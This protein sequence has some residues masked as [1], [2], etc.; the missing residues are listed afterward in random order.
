[1]LVDNTAPSGSVTA[2]P[3]HVAGRPSING[4]AK[5]SGSGIASWQLQIAPEGSSEWANACTVQRTPISG[6]DYGCT[7]NTTAHS[8][9]A[10]ELRAVITDNA[11]NI[12]TASAVAMDIDNAALSGSIA[13]PEPF[14][15][16]TIKLS[17]TGSSTG[18]SVAS[19]AVQIASLGSGAWSS[20]CATQTMPVSGSEYRCEMNSSGFTDGTYELR[21]VVTD[22]EGDTY[23]TAP[24]ETVIDN[25]PP[26]GALYQPPEKVVGEL[27]V[28]GYA[29]DNG[30]GVDTWTLERAPVGSESF[31]EACLPQTVPISGLIYGCT[32]STGSLTPGAYKLR[33]VILDGAGNTYTTS[34]VSTMVESS[35]LSLVSSPSISGEAVSEEALSVSTGSWSGTGTIGYSYQWRKCNSS[36]TECANIE[37]ATSNSYVL[38]SS[39]V[40]STL[41]VVVIASNG[42]EESSVTSSASSV[43]QANGLANITV[44]GISGSPNVGATV[45]AEPGRW[46]GVSP[47]SYGYQWQLC[48]GSGG[49]CS[50]I[51]GATVSA[52][53]LIEGDL[54]KTLRVVVT[55]TN[56]EGSKTATST[57]TAK[58]SSGSSS[59]IRYLY[60][61]VGRLHIV[62][63][64][65]GGAAVYSWDADGNLTGIKRYS[66]STLAVLAVTPAHA[67]PGTQVDITGTDFNTNPS[68]DE[69]HFNGISATVSK[70][71]VT[72]LIV[73]VPEGAT[74]GPI[75][76][77]IS[78]ESAESPTSFKPFVSIHR[79][80]PLPSTS[81]ASAPAITPTQ[82]PTVIHAMAKPAIGHSVRHATRLDAHRCARAKHDRA[83]KSRPQGGCAPTHKTSTSARRG[84]GR[85]NSTHHRHKPTRAKKAK[86]SKA[87]KFSAVTPTAWPAAQVPPASSPQSLTVPPAMSDYRSPYPTTWH[88]TASNR[89]DDNWVTGR[90][91]SPWA[92]LPALHTPRSTTGLSGQ[93]LAIS[94]EPL[95]NVT[96][97]IQGTSKQTRTDNTGRFLLG[98]LEP[99][100]Q[101]LIIEGE[102]AN[103]KGQHYGRFT[104]G[105]DL[106]KDKIMPLES[107]IWMTPLEAAGNR[108]IE[109]PLKHETTL[110]NPN[111]PGFEVRLPGGTTVTSANGNIVRHLNLTAIP[112]DRPPF[113]LPMFSGGVPTY[114]TVQP[115]SAYLNKGAQ[116]IYPNWGHLP[117]GQRV[118]FWNYNPSDKGWYVYGEGTVSKNGQQVVPDTN[119]RVWEFTGAMITTSDP[120]PTTGPVPGSPK[121]GDPVD[122]GTGLFVYQHN[123]L[124]L[125]DSTMP[126]TLTRTYRPDDENSYS[127][128]VG[129]QSPFD[130]HLWSNENYTTAYLVLPNGAKVK[131][132]RTS[133]GTGYIEAVY[134]A[135]ETSGPW[136][137]AVMHWDST[138]SQWIL[139]RRDGTNFI[140]GE[141]AP[142]QAIEDRNGNRI[143]LVREGGIKGPIVEIRTPHH[144]T[145]HLRYDSYNRIVEA[146]DSAGQRVVY[147]YDSK[148]RLV[149]VT[150]PMGRATR[151]AYNSANEMTKVISARGN[152]VIE[153]TYSPTGRVLTQT[154]GGAGTYTFN[155]LAA[156]SGCEAEGTGGTEVID[157]DGHKHDVYFKHWLPTAEVNNPGSSEEWKTYT[158]DASGN[159]VH[160]AGSTGNVSYTYDTYGNIT[161]VKQESSMLPSLVTTCTYNGFGEPTS[162]T[163][164]LGQTTSYSYD[165]NGNLVGT[166][167]PMGQHASY[168]YDGEG[169]LTSVTSPEGHKTTYSYA[170]GE[171]VGTTNPLGYETEVAYD[172]VGRPAAIR[173][174]EGDVTQ[175]SYDTDN[176][177]TGETNPVG[178][179]T[180]YA[181]DADGNTVE[182]IDPRGHEQT[183]NYEV[184]DRES[185]WTNALGETTNYAYDG[186][187]NLT[188]ITDPEGQTTSYAYNDLNQ[189]ASASFGATGGGSPTSSIS[190]SYNSEG[191]LTS[192]V[193]SRAGT[194]TL[195]YD[196]YHRLIKE[197]GPSGS[198][199]Y[200]YNTAGDRTS[201]SI[202]G[203]EAAS[204]TYDPDGQLTNISTPNGEVTFTYDQDGHRT[205]AILPNGDT[206]HFSYDAAGQLSSITYGKPGGEQIGNLQ[207]G[208][209]ALGRITT[210][211]GSYARTT[212]PEVMGEASYNAGN[213]LTSLE[214]H[215][216]TYNADGD[217][218]KDATSSY[219]WNDRNQLTKVTQ[220]ANTWSY[221]YDPFDRRISKQLNGAETTYLYDGENVA[222][223]S[224]EEGSAELI[225]GLT[226][227]NRYSR[228]TSAGTSSYL[229]DGLGS[230]IALAD[231]SGTPVTEYTYGPFGAMTASGSSSANTDTYTGLENDGD[232]LQYNR[233][234]YYSLVVDRFISEDP[235]GIRGSGMN[236]YRYAADDPIDE[237]DPSGMSSI[238]QEG[239][240]A[241]G[242]EGKVEEEKIRELEHEDDGEICKG[243]HN[244]AS[245]HDMGGPEP[246]PSPDGEQHSGEESFTG[247]ADEEHAPYKKDCGEQP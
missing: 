135:K 124:E 71:T 220:G 201:M 111:I 127:F 16:K 141:L 15:A 172:D 200:T 208:R 44:P 47:I 174:P 53:T 166:T 159:V 205:Q 163:N 1:M 63:D 190:Y 27:E 123:D 97:M 219:T 77:K 117:P 120:P 70:A 13:S 192:I 36:G 194:Y 140:F 197:T 125:P 185:S 14:I 92:S 147:G 246:S 157:P 81:L 138:N 224:S 235:L 145:I 232:G 199:G 139:H 116:I 153:N 26:M 122:L 130:I 85:A 95:S 128:G 160:I 171:R 165:S 100:H 99:G 240:D 129:T 48:N 177:I 10:Y 184:F 223:E 113:P 115:G 181:H 155:P 179:K 66:Q 32:I 93:A 6:E 134:E 7:V 237:S 212:L 148:G 221:A 89:R 239:E 156:C 164:P 23:T 132:A 119:V 188:S 162:I 230:T 196:P 225:N 76:V 238:G 79:Y 24:I 52:Y 180:S 5:D 4:T 59:G 195:E 236:L 193:D 191:D 84:H 98:G 22:T 154:L 18:P 143:T 189:L 54:T 213:E 187:G 178:E 150:D 75:T 233:A 182:V 103:H 55:A 161:S 45:S 43:V 227:D 169:E 158:H 57:A 247:E 126:I 152:V 108:K 109:S 37:G 17:G 2:P 33:A 241:F 229:A 142:L 34:V 204:Y 137:G 175:F 62:D 61:E 210:I 222:R 202:E 176:E 133:A 149:T 94:G 102:T 121:T 198:V 112:I 11:G 173:N 29:Y 215:A 131:L 74:T 78:S 167:T 28:H 56:S 105:V 91:P 183:A 206:E 68:L 49:E 211:A 104:V 21:A 118:D 12:H 242:H 114:F 110:T 90:A 60:D 20:A 31:T 42:L 107:T 86:T 38:S 9:G 80:G 72:D 151:Y 106:T 50:N 226:L 67:P 244:K 146:V 96:L 58:V 218:T 136:E 207:Y 39:D 245:G 168:G 87:K 82:D 203:K 40:G 3:S 88:P 243:E 65:S 228:T 30:S 216:L 46:A 19:W 41:R 214:G 35:S 69:V 170:D 51:G 234:R 144:R 8:D 209:D 83:S 25:T 64:P 73:T 101:V 217:L 186:L 231:E